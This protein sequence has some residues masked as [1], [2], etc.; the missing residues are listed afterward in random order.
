MCRDTNSYQRDLMSGDHVFT[1][2]LG[3]GIFAQVA[4]VL[5]QVGVDDLPYRDGYYVGL[6]VLSFD[7]V[8]GAVQPCVVVIE[9]VLHYLV[10]LLHIPAVGICDGCFLGGVV[11]DTVYIYLVPDD[12]TTLYDENGDN[13]GDQYYSEDNAPYLAVL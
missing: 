6:P 13:Q 2:G 9:E 12:R 10:D 7:H 5:E 1:V 11:R 3:F 8:Y 4:D